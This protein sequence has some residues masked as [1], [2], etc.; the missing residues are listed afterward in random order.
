MEKIRIDKWLWAIRLYKSRTLATEACDGGKVKMEGNNVKASKLISVGDTITVRHNHLTKI[1][2]VI[3]LIDKRVSAIL[4]AECYED[5][6]PAEV[7]DPLLKSVFYKAGG[8]R[9]KGA[10]RPTKRDRRDIDKFSDDDDFF[11]DK[12]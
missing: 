3:K 5:L 1:F 4:A 7:L 6:S 11:I 9:D 12:E 10:G 8:L 2:K